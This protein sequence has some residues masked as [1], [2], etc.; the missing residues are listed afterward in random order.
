[1]AL[2][3]LA[4]DDHCPCLK[5][6]ERGEICNIQQKIPREIQTHDQ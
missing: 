1:M 5:K 2:I 3:F 6:I 4:E